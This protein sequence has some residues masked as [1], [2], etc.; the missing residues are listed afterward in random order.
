MNLGG[1]PAI[2]QR[3]ILGSTNPQDIQRYLVPDQVSPPLGS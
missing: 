3:Y 2:V 1:K